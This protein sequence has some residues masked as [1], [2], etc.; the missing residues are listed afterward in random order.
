MET[1]RLC[2]ACAEVT[3]VSGTATMPMSGDV[4]P[5]SLCTT[6]DVSTLIEE[7]QYALGEGSCVDAFHQDRL[8]VQPDLAPLGI[9]RW[10]A[11]PVQRSTRAVGR[12]SG[13]R[14]RSAPFASEHST[15]TAT[16]WGR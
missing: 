8:V 16:A 10:P 4:P 13:S 5:G 12:S 2:E 15:S 9:P 11:S 14:S 1:K 6:N 3:G 7:F